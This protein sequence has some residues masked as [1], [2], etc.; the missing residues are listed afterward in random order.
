MLALFP[1]DLTYRK[2]AEQLYLSHN[3]VRTHAQR[4]RRK[5]DA[6]TRLEAVT[7]ARRWGAS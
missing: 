3:T 2:I 1:S 6:D 5:L 4:I 7:A